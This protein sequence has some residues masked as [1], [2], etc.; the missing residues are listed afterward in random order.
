MR[1][2]TKSKKMASKKYSTI[3]Q[4]VA[5][6]GPVGPALEA[7]LEDG[8]ITRYLDYVCNYKKHKGESWRRVFTEDRPY[9]N[10]VMTVMNPATKTYQV[11]SQLC[12][13]KTTDKNRVNTAFKIQS[14]GL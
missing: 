13:Q 6:L 8:D 2:G 7:L 1:S 14:A 12:D 4:P 10:W 9:F 3:A 5:A 11:L